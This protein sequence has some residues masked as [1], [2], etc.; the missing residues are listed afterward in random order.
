MDVNGT[1]LRVSGLG[2]RFSHSTLFFN[3]RT[4]PPGGVGLQAL[5]YFSSLIHAGGSGK[6]VLG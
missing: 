2:Y 5:F 6:A 4:G 3:V 1:Y